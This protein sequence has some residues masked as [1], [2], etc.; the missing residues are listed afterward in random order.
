MEVLGLI[1]GL[2]GL[3]EIIQ[4]TAEVANQLKNWRSLASEMDTLL[5]QLEGLEKTLKDV[6]NG[7]AS[8]SISPSQ[9]ANFQASLETIRKDLTNLRFD[10]TTKKHIERIRDARAEL[11]LAIV[12]QVHQGYGQSRSKTDL[13]LQL[14]RTLCPSSSNFIPPKLDATCDW[15]WSYDQ[16]DNWVNLSQDDPSDHLQRLFCLYGPKGCGKSVLSASI[17]DA[18]QAKA[19]ISTFFSY[20]A[21]SE[22][23]RKFTGFLKPTLWQLL[24]YLSAEDISH[25]ASILMQDVSFGKRLLRDAL[26]FTIRA[27][28]SEVYI[29]IDGVDEAENDWNNPGD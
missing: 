7:G 16:L 27:I 10:K 18:F 17:A 23:Q 14:K 4:K 24:K 6:Q 25:V 28:D 3:N 8:P 21:R 11:T 26:D 19:K 20:W 9:V 13:L 1:A 29:I 2:P 5:Q 22:S 12:G 15:I